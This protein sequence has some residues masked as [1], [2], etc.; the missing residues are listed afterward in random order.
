MII[1]VYM[2]PLSLKQEGIVNQVPL[3]EAV[4]L[5]RCMTVVCQF[6]RNQK[7]GSQLTLA[8]LRKLQVFLVVCKWM[9]SHVALGRYLGSQK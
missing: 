8:L 9:K 4:T 3:D 1:M 7:R 6:Y 5:L 2:A